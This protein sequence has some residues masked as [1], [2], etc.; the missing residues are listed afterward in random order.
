VRHLLVFL[1]SGAVL[2]AQPQLQITAPSNGTVVNPGQSIAVTVAASGGTFQGV[3]VVAWNP[4]PSTLPLASPP[5][6]F[7]IEIPND[8]HAGRYLLTASGYTSPGHGI[9]S[10]SITIVVEPPAT[11]I[12]NHLRIEP[13]SLDL[14]VSRKGY[15]HVVGVFGDDKTA[16]LRKSEYVDY[17]SDAPSVASIQKEGIVTAVAPGSATIFITY[18]GVEAR[19]PVTVRE[20][21]Q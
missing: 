2:S 11:A 12:P 13:E 4:I 15:L 16:D 18:R 7:Q 3:M 21:R 14:S 9:D 5:Y 6:Q 8:I 20:S 10:P 19:V 1:F 17:R